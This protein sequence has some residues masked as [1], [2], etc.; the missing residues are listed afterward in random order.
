MNTRKSGRNR[1]CGKSY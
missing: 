1:N